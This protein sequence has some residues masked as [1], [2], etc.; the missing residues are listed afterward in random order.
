MYFSNLPRRKL[1][2]NVRKH[3]MAGDGN[4]FVHATM[5]HPTITTVHRPI[6]NDW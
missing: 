2:V 3:Q 4:L 1:V 6:R 5:A